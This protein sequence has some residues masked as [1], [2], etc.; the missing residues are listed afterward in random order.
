MLV[1]SPD[2]KNLEMLV[3]DGNAITKD[4]VKK[5]KKS[6]VKHSAKELISPEGLD[7]EPE[8]LWYGDME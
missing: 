7:D 8:Y 1:E 6:A 4:G 5:L 3:L 2:L